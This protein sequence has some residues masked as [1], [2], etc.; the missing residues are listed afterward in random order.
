MLVTSDVAHDSRVVREAA[1]LARAGHVVHVQGRDVPTGWEAPGALF[2]VGSSTGGEGLRRAA[3][4]GAAAGAGRPGLVWRAARW[5]LLPRHRDRVWSGWAA[6]VVRDLRGRVF[7]V[8]HAHDFNTLPTAARLAGRQG[9]LLVYD[10]HE[11]WS[12]RQRHGR[13]T[14]WRRLAERRLEARLTGRA[15]AVVTVSYGI[16]RRLERWAAGPVVV[17]RNTF[18]TLPAGQKA[19]PPLPAAPS[20]VVYA[21]RIG[22]GRDLETVLRGAAGRTEVVLV[23]PADEA[24]AARLAGRAGAVLLP[25]RPVDAVDGLLRSRGL[26]VVTLTD[27]C[28]NHRLALPNKLFHAVRAGVPVIAADLPELRGEVLRHDLGELYRPGDPASFAAALDRARARYPRLLRSVAAA[29]PALA[30][31]QDARRLVAVY[32]ALA[33]RRRGDQGLADRA[34]RRPVGRPV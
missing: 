28:A 19:G 27:S 32:A 1:A 3:P 31:E 8:V 24:Y 6:A 26:A 16:A 29:G 15:D 9:A 21:G 23:G 30:W 17:V 34:R 2:T 20:G 33:A 13:P 10:A 7:D 12:G 5:W 25:P 4:S 11:W 14:P 22:A 18:P